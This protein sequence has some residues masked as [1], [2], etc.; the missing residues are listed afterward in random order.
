MLLTVATISSLLHQ[1][2]K[3]KSPREGL[4]LCKRVIGDIEI[5]YGTRSS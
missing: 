5:Y 4:N 1:D 2:T 3:N